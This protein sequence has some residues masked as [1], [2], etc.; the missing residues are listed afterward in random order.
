[1][2]MSYEGKVN[3]LNVSSRYA[4]LKAKA[5][6]GQLKKLAGDMTT[7]QLN[8]TSPEVWTVN[9][10]ATLRVNSDMQQKAVFK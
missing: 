5:C 6:Q 10:Y 7:T 9:I 8:P 3:D 2:L 4:K 1:M